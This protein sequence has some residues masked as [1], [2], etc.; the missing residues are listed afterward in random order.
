MIRN[1]SHQQDPR[2]LSQLRTWRNTL[3]GISAPD[4]FFWGHA[5]RS[6]HLESCSTRDNSLASS[7]QCRGLSS[8]TGQTCQPPR[9]VMQ[10]AQTSSPSRDLSLASSPQSAASLCGFFQL[11]V[12]QQTWSSGFLTL[13]TR[14][15]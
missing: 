3:K 11:P 14:V 1:A 6:A 10:P 15:S 9:A 13:V 12:V 8:C 7:P 2:A 4:S 5:P